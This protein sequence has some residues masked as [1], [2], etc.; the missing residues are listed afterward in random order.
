MGR[1]RREQK[2]ALPRRATAFDDFHEWVLSLPWVVEREHKLGTP[3]ARSFGVE[4]E[5]LGRSQLWLL[6]GLPG[7][8]DSTSLASP[9]SCPPTLRGASNERVGVR[10]SRTCPTVTY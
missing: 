9:S 4:C 2:S 8:L 5:P 1:R 10:E 3:G 7:H 6:T